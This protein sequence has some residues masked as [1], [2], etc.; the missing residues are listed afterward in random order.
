M[1]S[2]LLISTPW[3]Q[4]SYSRATAATAVPC[5]G[6]AGQLKAARSIACAGILV[7]V[8]LMPKLR[9][10]K[11]SRMGDI[12]TDATMKVLLTA[13]PHLDELRLKSC[14]TIGLATLR[15]I[16]HSCQAPN[17]RVLDLSGAATDRHAMVPLDA[18]QLACPNIEVLRLSGFGGMFGW[19]LQR[20]HSAPRLLQARPGAP[21]EGVVELATV[22][23]AG[24]QALPHDKAAWSLLR[25]LT[26]GR[27][28]TML[29]TGI[30]QGSSFVDD[31]VLERFVHNSTRL[32]HLDISGCTRITSEGLIA[33][34]HH[35]PL[36]SL[37][38]AGSA[39][40]DTVQTA[41]LCWGNSLQELDVSGSV[42]VTSAS[43]RAITEHCKVLTSLSLG[44][45]AVREED[46]QAMVGAAAVRASLRR[47]DT[48]GCRSLP[49]Q[50]RLPVASCLSAFTEQA[51]EDNS[52]GAS[53]AKASPELA[54]VAAEAVLVRH[55]TAAGASR[56][57][58]VNVRTNRLHEKVGDCCSADGLA[59]IHHPVEM[60]RGS[61][62]AVGECQDISRQRSA[63][64][65]SRE[66][67]TAK[68][69]PSV[70]MAAAKPAPLVAECTMRGREE[71]P[72]RS[73]EPTHSSAHPVLRKARENA[74]RSKRLPSWLQ[75]AVH[76]VL[77]PST[78]CMP[79]AGHKRQRFG[80]PYDESQDLDYVP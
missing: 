79:T 66:H 58:L 65:G 40:D 21:A 39:H 69:R 8:G 20:G 44:G 30:R 3:L 37:S 68:L 38:M 23:S 28:S 49:R 62:E 46:V 7:A 77:G 70:R 12:V 11:A 19:V 51:E 55:A 26:L 56:K 22:C 1:P 34:G 72:G 27:A 5:G 67:R 60:V 76:A 47:L 61:V 33:I 42:R 59:H 4:T 14:H 36:K 29:N 71:L 57:T 31:S 2:W 78:V 24:G 6:P 15:A 74:R 13:A 10:F 48:V 41:V 73:S 25:V 35:A 16:A 50:L 17:L 80:A 53:R 54:T 63:R 32:E 45:S 18:L 52:G 9:A 64:V 43:T 75:P